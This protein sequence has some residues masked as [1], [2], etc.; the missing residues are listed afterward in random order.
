RGGL[1]L[2][3]AAVEEGAAALPDA[4]LERALAAVAGQSYAPCTM[5]FAS[6]EAAWTMSIEDGTPRV[7]PVPPGWHVLT[8]A[9]LD[10]PSEPRTARLMRELQG[11]APRDRDQAERRLADLLRSHDDPPVCLHEGRMTTVS[12]AIVWLAPGEAAY[13]HAEGRPCEQPFADCTALL[14]AGARIGD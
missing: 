5:V 6:P 8:H 7:G 13:R 10:D 12:S 11:F 1:V 9:D 14:H 2:D 4:A 3:V